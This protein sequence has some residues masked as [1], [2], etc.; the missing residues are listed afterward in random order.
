M[1]LS[2]PSIDVKL[3]ERKKESFMFHCF[4]IPRFV[5][6]LI[7]CYV[8]YCSIISFS[9]FHR[10]LVSLLFVSIC[11]YFIIVGFVLP[12]LCCTIVSLCHYFL[13][14]CSS[15]LLFH[16]TIVFTTLLCYFKYPFSLPLLI[17]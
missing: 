12:L 2:G 8:F 13:A 6:L 11:L 1:D 9:L 10:S 7:C 14:I 5:A 15:L 16:S 17:H 4:I 3:K